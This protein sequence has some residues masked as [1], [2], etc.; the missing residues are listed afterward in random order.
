MPTLGSVHTNKPA[1]I[2]DTPSLC[3]EFRIAYSGPPEQ[4]WLSVFRTYSCAP[5]FSPHCPPKNGFL[6]ASNNL[7]LNLS[8]GLTPVSLVSIAENSSHGKPP[9]SK[10]RVSSLLH[11]PEFPDT[12]MM[13]VLIW[14]E[15]GVSG[16]SWAYLQ[17]RGCCQ[18]AN[19]TNELGEFEG[20]RK[21]VPEVKLGSATLRLG[22]GWELKS[23]EEE[24]WNECLGL[25]EQKGTWKTA[26]GLRRWSSRKEETAFSGV[27]R[28]ELSYRLGARGCSGLLPLQPGQEQNLGSS[29]AIR[30]SENN[31]R[32]LH[33][34]QYWFIS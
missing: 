14:A 19:L 28:R 12:D 18:C 23:T 27:K 33:L 9:D 32:N 24:R 30:V 4:M 6:F 26:G 16:V 2:S 25:S 20:R 31:R 3:R 8:W 17:A 5:S 34:P 1:V 11:K 22:T 29:G 15:D 13:E 7:L 10:G 21:F